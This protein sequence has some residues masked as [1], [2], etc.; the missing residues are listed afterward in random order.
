[1]G[2]R[3][4]AQDTCTTDSLHYRN[5]ETRTLRGLFLAGLS[6]ITA[7]TAEPMAM[8]ATML[9]ISIHM[10]APPR[11]RHATRGSLEPTTH[12]PGFGS[13]A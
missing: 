7:I 5:A 2:G 11:L 13:G 8:A 1:M 12:K 10:A 4:A 3:K 6:M 9:N